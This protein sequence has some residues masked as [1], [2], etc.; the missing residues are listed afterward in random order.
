MS[1]LVE[2]KPESLQVVVQRCIRFGVCLSHVELIEHVIYVCK[3]EK[4]SF[5]N[6]A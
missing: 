6:V 3:A 1:S 5:S 2:C 4:V